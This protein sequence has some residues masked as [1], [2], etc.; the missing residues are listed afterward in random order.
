M[1][2]FSYNHD[3]ELLVLLDGKVIARAKDCEG[4]ELIKHIVSI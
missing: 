2:S 3:G 1:I 4:Y